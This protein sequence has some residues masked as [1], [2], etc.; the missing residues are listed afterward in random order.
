MALIVRLAWRA[1]AAAC[2]RRAPSTPRRETAIAAMKGRQATE[3]RRT[4]IDLNL[5]GSYYDDPANQPIW[6]EERQADAGCRRTARSA[7][8]RR[9]RRARPRRLSERARSSKPNRLAGDD[10]A[11][12]YELAMSQAFLTFAR[13]IH[14]GQTSPAVNASD[15][16]IPRKPVDAVAWLSLARDSGVEGALEKLRPEPSAI[17]PASPDAEGLPHARRQRR[18]AGDRQGRRA[19][20]RHDRPAHRP[21]ARQS[22]GARL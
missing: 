13:D 11:A 1:G 4:V 7:V 5:V 6:V 10:D 21:D 2:A 14:S 19:E 16:V 20:A 8:A 22:Q 18:L 12:G 9:R 17:F 15:I 3:W